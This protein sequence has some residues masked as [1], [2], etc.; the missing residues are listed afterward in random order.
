MPSRRMRSRR[1]NPWLQPGL[2]ADVFATVP[3]GA[4][5]V[6]HHRSHNSPSI[7][8]RDPGHAAVLLWKA[9]ATS[10]DLGDSCCPIDAPAAQAAGA[11]THGVRNTA[12]E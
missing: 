5:A 4:V 10:G 11:V 6:V 12:I 7:R 1:A 8:Q 3:T 9:A 2:H